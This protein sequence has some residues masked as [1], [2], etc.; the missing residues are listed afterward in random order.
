LFHI[1]F[2]LV[3]TVY[4]SEAKYFTN[5]KVAVTVSISSPQSNE[6]VVQAVSTDGSAQGSSQ[7]H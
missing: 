6:V 4:F 7:S 2:S 1:E 3:P 5:D